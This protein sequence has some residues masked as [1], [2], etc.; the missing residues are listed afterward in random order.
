MTRIVQAAL[1]APTLLLGCATTPAPATAS[2]TA[3]ADAGVSGTGTPD[4][5]FRQTLPEPAAQHITEARRCLDELIREVQDHVFTGHG[6]QAQPGQPARPGPDARE[7][8]ELAASHRVALREQGATVREQGAAVRERGAAVRER[9]TQTAYALHQAA[10]DT[11]ALLERQGA[12]V[13]QPGRIDYPTEIKRWRAFA[14][15]AKQM[16]ERWEH[17]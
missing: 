13:E 3:R 8:G 4:A 17:P 6:Q 1:L 11:A 7:R 9:V 16:A 5:P 14:D 10:A 2:A 12:L 15:Q